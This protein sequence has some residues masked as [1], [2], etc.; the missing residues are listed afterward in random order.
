MPSRWLTAAIVLFW[1]ATTGWLF[2]HDLWPAWRPG[3]PPPFH[4][5][6]VEEVQSANTMRTSWTVAHDEGKGEGVK[7]VFTATTKAE[8][9]PTNDTFSLIAEFKVPFGSKVSP[10]SVG[11]EVGKGKNNGYRVI[12]KEMESEYRVNRQGHL[13]SLHAA[14]KGKLHLKGKEMDAEASLGGEVR[15]EQ[16][17]AHYRLRRSGRYPAGRRFQP[18][19][20]FLPRFHRDAVASGQSH[21]RSETGPKLAS[22]SHRSLPRCVPRTGGRRSLSPGSRPGT[23]ANSR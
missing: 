22:S 16:F 4:I 17:F 15:D 13:Q 21:P 20:D 23:T 9:H 7:N 10:V 3:E 18:G 1:L 11:E 5:D 6:L 2:W 19:A 14:I 12:V 8:Y